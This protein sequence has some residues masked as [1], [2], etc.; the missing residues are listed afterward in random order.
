[1]Q[2]FFADAPMKKKKKNFVSPRAEHF[3]DT[4]YKTILNF[5][6]LIQK[7]SLQTPVE[8]FFRYHL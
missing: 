5:F 3:F 8:V 2:Y 1:M 7:I 6:A 4:Q